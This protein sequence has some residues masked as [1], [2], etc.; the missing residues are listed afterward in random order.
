M[1]SFSF[2][3]CNNTISF[4]RRIGENS[5]D[6]NA[7]DEEIILENKIDEKDY[8][9]PMKMLNKKTK[10][11]K[12]QSTNFITPSNRGRKKKVGRAAKLPKKK[13]EI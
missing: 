5:F 2:A 12:N 3:F 13:L 10:R 11:N 9:T 6:F 1:E 8:L 7:F 4:C